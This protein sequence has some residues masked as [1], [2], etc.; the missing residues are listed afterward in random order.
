MRG[1]NP[2][3]GDF[4]S[5]SRSQR[6]RDA[7]AVLGLAEQL[8][9]LTTQQLAKLQ[10]P[11]LVLDAVND[12]R[13]INSHIARKRQLHFLAKLLR[14]EDDALL[15]QF[16]GQLGQDRGESRRETAQLHRIEQWRERLL[17][18]GGA[19]LDGLCELHPSIDREPLLRLIQTAQS[20]HRSSKPPK[21]FREIFQVL[22]QAFEEP[23]ADDEPE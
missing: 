14:R 15:D 18:D 19:A 9:S 1:R 17:K 23:S 5:P 10:L 12:T 6:K 13:R 8:V 16:R 4:L 21:A 2:E 7:V 20:E 22:K 3:S 11:D